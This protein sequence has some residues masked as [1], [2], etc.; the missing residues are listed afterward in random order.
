[1]ATRTSTVRPFDGLVRALRPRTLDPS[2]R[3]RTANML[4]DADIGNRTLVGVLSGADEAV[5]HSTRTRCVAA[6]TITDVGPDLGSARP[7]GQ[8]VD[9]PRRAFD[10]VDADWAWTNPAVDL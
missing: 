5:Y 9:D 8:A 7:L 2:I 3:E 4:Y 1:M 6:V 10:H